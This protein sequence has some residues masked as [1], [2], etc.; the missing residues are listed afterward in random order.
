MRYSIFLVV[1]IVASCFAAITGDTRSAVVFRREVQAKTTSATAAR[2]PNTHCM[3][4]ERVIFSCALKRPA[5]IVSLCASRTLTRDSGYLQYRFGLAGKIE[6]EFPERREGSREQFRYMHYF[7]AQFDLNE[8]SFTRNGYEYS[9]FDDYNGEEKPAVS[10]EGLSIKQPGAEQK[11][12]R[13]ICRTKPKTDYTDLQA[14]LE[15]H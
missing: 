2:Q 1:V 14:V 10:L 8:I 11:E 6:L 7:R 13:F 4:D 3:K 15:S 9:I 12:T 5:K